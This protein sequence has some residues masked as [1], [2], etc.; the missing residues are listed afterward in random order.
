LGVDTQNPADA[1]GLYRSQGYVV[2]KE[3]YDLVRP[4][5]R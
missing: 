3:F 4:M 2:R 5:D 1:I